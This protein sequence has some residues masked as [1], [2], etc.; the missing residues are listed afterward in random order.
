MQDD[1]CMAGALPFCMPNPLALI[2]WFQGYLE[3]PKFVFV[4][5]IHLYHDNRVFPHRRQHR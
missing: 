4:L 1:S 3:S 2:L 5:E